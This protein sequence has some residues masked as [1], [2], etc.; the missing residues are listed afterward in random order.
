MASTATE[1]AGSVARTAEQNGESA[2]AKSIHESVQNLRNQSD[3][4]VKTLAHVG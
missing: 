3:I 2:A 4:A 1:E